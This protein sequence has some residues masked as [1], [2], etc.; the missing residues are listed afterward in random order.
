MENYMI[1]LEGFIEEWTYFGVCSVPLDGF[2]SLMELAFG[3][4]AILY[5]LELKTS[6]R[7]RGILVLHKN[8]KQILVFIKYIKVEQEKDA[9]SKR[10]CISHF[11]ST[12]CLC[13]YI[14]YNCDY[15]GCLAVWR[16]GDPDNAD[17]HF[18]AANRSLFPRHPN[19]S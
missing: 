7:D 14:S 4:G 3:L 10:F 19:A 15:S 17:L 11:S 6:L 5:Y 1:V 13:R 2:S 9:F 8:A 12:T 18:R 16:I